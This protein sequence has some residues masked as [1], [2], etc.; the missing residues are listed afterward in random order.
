LEC[1]VCGGEGGGKCKIGTC[2]L[3]GDSG[4]KG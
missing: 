1:R 4:T 2:L 3:R